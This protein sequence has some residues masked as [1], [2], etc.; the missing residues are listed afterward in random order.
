MKTFFAMVLG[1]ALLATLAFA[2]AADEGFQPARVVSID[3]VPADARHPEKGDQY[4]VSMRL[5][6][7]LYL[8]QASASPAVFLDWSPNKEFP[9]KLEGKTLLVNGPHGQVQ[10]NVTGKKTAK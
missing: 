7:M 8:C 4:K 1:G 2:Q 3:R 5:G 10:L 6:D 9:A